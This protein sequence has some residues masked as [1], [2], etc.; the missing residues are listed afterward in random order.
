M[1]LSFPKPSS[2]SLLVSK[3]PRTTLFHPNKMT[4]FLNLA[5]GVFFV[6]GLAVLLLIFLNRRGKG[7]D[8]DGFNDLERN[9]QSAKGAEES[10]DLLTFQGG[11]DLTILDI[12]EA[13]GEVIGK[14][15]HGTLYKAYLQ[16]SSTVRL[17]R[18]L[19]PVCTAGHDDFVSEIEFLGSIRH[20]NLV[21]LLGFYSGPRTEKLL[22]HPFYRRGNLAQFIRDGNGDSHRWGV[23]NKISI[24]I[25]KGLDHLHTGLQKPTIH[26]NLQS[27]NV[28][29][30]RNYE[31]YVSDFGLHLL[32]NSSSAQEVLE[33]LAAN[34]YKA[35]E[36]I[37]MKDA[38]EETDVYSYGVILL[39]LL[40]GK[41]PVN[42]KPAFDEDFYLPNFMRNAVLGH[43]I[44][45]LFH[46]EILLYSS[47]DGNN[48]TEEK[49][50]K[51]F[52]LAMACCSPSPALRPS[53]KQVLRKL[54]EIG[55]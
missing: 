15:N 9:Q 19:R 7:K 32:L 38:T 6:L 41:E 4:Q 44:A 53:M 18:F 42:E 40:S 17:L 13:P 20:P 16:G 50:L 12:L 46:P 48:V 36:V 33:G 5:L 49:I 26:G 24:G 3:L 28:L 37:K 23:I 34:G 43:R 47:I 54:N 31:P 25:A 10:E 1:L 2:S 52:Q 11:Q 30:D 29:L 14:A 35:P 22:I 27:K 21:P 45:D 51:F 8:G 55:T 39:E